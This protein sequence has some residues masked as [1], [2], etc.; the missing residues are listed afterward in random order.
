MNENFSPADI[1]PEVKQAVVNYLA[2]RVYAE[3]KR[4]EVDAF[5]N[6]LLAGRF[7]FY[8]TPRRGR[9]GSRITDHR[10]LYQSDDEAGCKC[11]WAALSA[12]EKKVGIKPEDMPDDHCPALVAEF[13]RTKAEWALLNAA[14]K[15]LQIT[16]HREANELNSGLLCQ[17]DGLNKRQQFIDA[18]VGLVLAAEDEQLNR[19]SVR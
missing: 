17:P 16:P 9:D 7:E 18:I 10:K 11:F 15:M 6:E 12:E 13:D 3:A 1:T 5:A 19:R 4:S 8:S 2:A 14:D